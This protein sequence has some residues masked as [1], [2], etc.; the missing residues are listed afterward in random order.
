MTGP[1]DA[2]AFTPDVELEYGDLLEGLGAAVFAIDMEGRF[3][4]LN[5]S[6]LELLGYAPDEAKL[7]IGQHFVTIVAPE[8][9]KA[10]EELFR[11]GRTNRPR[12]MRALHKDGTPLEVEVS[13]DWVRQR[14]RRVGALAMVWELSTVDAEAE[15]ARG[16]SKL[17]MTILRL[18]SDGLSNREIAERV[19]LST[20]TI[21]DRIEKIMRAFGV[22]RRTELAAK[23]ARQGLV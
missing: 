5:G 14:G 17:D 20:H 23:A 6:A 8:Q 12:S 22:S 21:K 2:P 11:G 7:L 3:V 15:P 10:A 4:Y 1:D 18:L 9:A 19:Y 13:G 16:L